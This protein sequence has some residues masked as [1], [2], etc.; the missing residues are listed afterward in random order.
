MGIRTMQLA[1]GIYRQETISIIMGR[2]AELG[3]QRFFVAANLISV[4]LKKI[5][6]E[7]NTLLAHKDVYENL[8]SSSRLMKMGIVC[9]IIVN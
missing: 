1:V 9:S 6:V 8:F 5:I 7:V 2:Y 3:F 4:V